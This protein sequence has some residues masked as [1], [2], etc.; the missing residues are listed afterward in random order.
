[1]H[2][3]K[4]LEIVVADLKAVVAHAKTPD[5]KPRNARLLLMASDRVRASMETALKIHQAMRDIDQVDGLL[6]AIIEEIGRESPEVK[7]RI[8]R[9]IAALAPRYGG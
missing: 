1:V 6:S 7:E 4:E 3:I 5:G 2:L 8:L 9:R